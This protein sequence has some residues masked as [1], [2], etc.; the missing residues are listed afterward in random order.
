LLS[1]IIPTLNAAKTLG[2]VLSIFNDSNSIGNVQI[3][4]V[5]GGSHDSTC[6]IAEANGAKFVNCEKSRGAQLSKGAQDSSGDWLLFLHADTVL[7]ANWS[8]EMIM[9]MTDPK[10]YRRAG[11]FRFGLDD[12]LKAAKRLEVIVNWRAKVFGLPYGDQGLLI[13]REFYNY[14]GGFRPIPIME[15]VDMIRRIG[16]SRL[17][18]FES[19]A[20][21]SATRYR[22]FGYT[23]RSLRNLF[24]LGLYFM[25][26]KPSKLIRFYQ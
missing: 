18:H 3:L 10:N 12:R 16:R 26:V 15:D 14:L 17:V 22:Q 5:D 7:T 11:V 13:K 9:F 24:C 6:L 4:V 20:R 25:G 23:W 19:V 21:T 2:S 1:I 8:N